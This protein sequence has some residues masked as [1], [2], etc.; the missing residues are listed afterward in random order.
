MEPKA[1]AS[2]GGP[3]GGGGT[4][5]TDPTRESLSSVRGRE[6]TMVGG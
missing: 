4:T 5:V 6:L 1:L 3:M 2:L